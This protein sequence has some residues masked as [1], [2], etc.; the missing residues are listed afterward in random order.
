L[1]AVVKLTKNEDADGCVSQHDVNLMRRKE[2]NL[3][4]SAGHGFPSLNARLVQCNGRD[5]VV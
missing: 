5:K 3:K 1:K 4:M 2:S